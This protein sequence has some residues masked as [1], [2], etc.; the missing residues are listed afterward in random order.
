M[1]YFSFIDLTHRNDFLVGKNA[2]TAWSLVIDYCAKLMIG[3]L[4]YQ[5][6]AAFWKYSKKL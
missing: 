6:I 4:I 3:Y 1:Y 5:F 2:F